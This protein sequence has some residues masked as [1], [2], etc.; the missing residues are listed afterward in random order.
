MKLTLSAIG[1]I[2]MFSVSFAAAQARDLQHPGAEL[3]DDV[4]RTARG[5]L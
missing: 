2:F 5:L 1:V 3:R 4:G